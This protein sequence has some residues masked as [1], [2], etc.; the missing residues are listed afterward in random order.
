MAVVE[1]LRLNLI[2]MSYDRDKILNS[3]QRTGAT[4][5][6]LHTPTEYTTPLIEGGEEELRSYLAKKED[7]HARL[8]FAVQKYITENKINSD[9]PEKDFEISYSDFINANSLK[10][11]V[12]AFCQEVDKLFEDNKNY[13]AELVKINRT[14]Q[15]ATLYAGVNCPLKIENTP[16]VHFEVG[17]ILT[18]TKENFI[19]TFEAFPLSAYSF[20]PTDSEWEIVTLA[21]HKGESENAESSLPSLGFVKCPF[22]DG[23]SGKEI[24][25]SLLSRKEQIDLEI[26]ENTNRLFELR[27]GIKDLEIY[28]DYLAFELEKKQVASKLLSTDATFLLQAYVPKGGEEVVK[29][30]IEKISDAIY[31]EFSTPSPDEMPPTY[32]KNNG[33]IK[34]FEAITNMYSPPN[35][36][37]F[38]PNTVMA[39][40]YSVFLGF[41]MAD[42]GYGLSMILGGGYIWLKSLKK[43]SMMGKLGGVFCIGGIF[44][45]IWGVLFNSFFGFAALPFKVMPD[46]QGKNMSWSLSGINVPALL[47]VSM[48]IG[49]GQIF[50]GYVCKA[51]QSFRKGDILDG[52]FDGLV[53][54]VFSIGVA[55][56]M[57]AF[58]EE[59]K[60]SNLQPIGGI[61]SAASLGIAVLT[62]GRKEKFIGKFTKGFG[63][64]YGVI[65]Y[66]SDILSY[67]RLYGLMLAGAV[68]ADIITSNSVKLIC[69][70]NVAFIIL[71]IAIMVIGHVFNLAI[72]LLGAYIHDARL[73]YVEFYGRFF[74]GEGKLFT[75]LGSKHKYISIMRNA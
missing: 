49:V 17:A 58:V 37:E 66:A 68:I 62:A 74:E 59:F 35:C 64:A 71:G 39:F 1:M 18:K 31:F 6:K 4:E 34:N 32:L 67:A 61:I 54:A 63:S 50:A 12:D 53:W 55:I 47:V 72:G 38:D 60:L 10:E 33:V 23:W 70:G 44:T 20:T 40:F 65:N 5:I 11:Q 36:K 30:S 25:D 16:H 29:S 2:A 42:V 69:T 7:T 3:L 22:K 43:E 73:Q 52:I 48:L 28:C 41:I 26:R 21:F 14:L 57:V 75:P 19:K 13:Q 24:Y 46:L 8:V 56:T 15:D 9:L 45:V 51:W 27:K